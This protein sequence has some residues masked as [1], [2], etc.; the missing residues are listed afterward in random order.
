MVMTSLTPK[1]L[2]YFVITNKLMYAIHFSEAVNVMVL[3]SF[4][5][6]YVVMSCIHWVKG[7]FTKYATR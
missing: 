6:G 4:V 1:L 2:L 3:C 5:V 7:V